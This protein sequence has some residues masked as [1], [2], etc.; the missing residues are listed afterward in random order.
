M[1]QRSAKGRCVE[2]DKATCVSPALT[3]KIAQPHCE[4][5]YVLSYTA[6]CYE[7]CV[8]STDCAP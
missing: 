5:D 6:S 7:G 2:G 3:C 1:R 4:G 8:K